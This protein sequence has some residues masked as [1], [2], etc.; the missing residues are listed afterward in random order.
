VALAVAAFAGAEA[1]GGIASY[2]LACA[3]LAFA[4]RAVCVV[5]PPLDGLREYRQ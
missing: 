5:L 4:C 3:T 1:V 2:V